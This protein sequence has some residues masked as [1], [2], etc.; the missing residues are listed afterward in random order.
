[1]GRLEP[2]AASHS[3]LPSAH[4]VCTFVRCSLWAAP[5]S[6]S[7][8]YRPCVRL[9]FVSGRVAAVGVLSQSLSS[10]ELSSSAVSLVRE[11]S[12]SAASSSGA[13]CAVCGL[14]LRLEVGG[15]AAVGSVRRLC[16][17][18]CSWWVRSQMRLLRRTL[19]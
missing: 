14:R 17:M 9:V 3:G 7:V 12:S 19:E 10:S 18:L 15:V 8:G 2:C 13:R 4:R 11:V 1:M 16:V 6:P 5:S